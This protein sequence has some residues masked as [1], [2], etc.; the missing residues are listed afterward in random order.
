MQS[1]GQV[2]IFQVMPETPGLDALLDAAGY[3]IKDPVILYVAPLER[4]AAIPTPRLST[5]AL[6]P[7]LAVQRE[8][9][10][11]GGIGADR[12]AVM[13]RVQGDKTALLARRDDRPVGVGFAAIHNR[14]VMLHALEVRP[15]DRRKAMPAG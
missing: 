6:W 13:E 2:P 15:E 1:W 9:W 12:V 4:I 3:A 5:F 11:A 7:P 10:A 14:I 8:I